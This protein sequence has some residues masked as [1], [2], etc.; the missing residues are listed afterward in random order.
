MS[1]ST[2]MITE[3][4]LVELARSETFK[5]V[6]SIAR[7][8]TVL[9]IEIPEWKDVF[10]SIKAPC[11]STY[12]SWLELPLPEATHSAVA[13]LVTNAKLALFDGSL[14]GLDML[15]AAV[16]ALLLSIRSED[17][18]SASRLFL[19]NLVGVLDQTLFA[20]NS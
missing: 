17:G 9:A 8:V 3:D 13:E 2:T 18:L 14:K 16:K 5:K 12:G 1:A 19:S 11:A 4:D 15:R 10:A 20:V 7:S 6:E